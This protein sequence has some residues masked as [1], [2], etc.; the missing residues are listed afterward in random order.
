MQAVKH[1]E[2][3]EKSNSVSIKSL[4]QNNFEELELLRTEMFFQAE[5]KASQKHTTCCLVA[6]ESTAS[7]FPDFR[8]WFEVMYLKVEEI[9]W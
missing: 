6:R 5:R 9:L 8:D 2:E 1:Q 4:G 3:R 7:P